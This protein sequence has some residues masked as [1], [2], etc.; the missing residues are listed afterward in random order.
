MRDALRLGR[1]ATIEVTGLR[2]PCR[3]LDGVVPGLMQATLARDSDGQLVR[4]AGVMAVVLAGGEVRPGD[5]IDVEF[6]APPHEPLR[7]V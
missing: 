6:P 7:P 3:Q 1:D 5:A 2:N 4:K